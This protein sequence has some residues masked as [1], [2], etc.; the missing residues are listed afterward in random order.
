M[1]KRYSPDD[2]REWL[3]RARSSLFMAKKESDEVYLEDLCYQAQQAVEK[4]IKAIFVKRNIEFPYTH[5]ISQLLS[6]VENMDLDVPESIMEAEELT[7][8]ATII[9]YPGVA[10]PIEREKYL[11]LIIIAE[12]VVHWAE[13]VI[14]NKGR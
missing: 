8:F 12:R 1:I 14:L 11:E 10:P 5:D 9:R 6:L 3:N 2:P 4:A 13:N 7:P